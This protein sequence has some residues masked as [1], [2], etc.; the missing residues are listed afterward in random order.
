MCAFGTL[1]DDFEKLWGDRL[2]KGGSFPIQ[3][4]HGE[5]KQEQEQ[6]NL[7]LPIDAEYMEANK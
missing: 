5:Q 1:G 2:V 3:L 6:E 4:V 7:D